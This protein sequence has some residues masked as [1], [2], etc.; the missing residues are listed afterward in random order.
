MKSE[1][2][3]ISLCIREIFTV[4]IT[5]NSKVL[6]LCARNRLKTR[7]IF[8]IIS[9]NSLPSNMFLLPPTEGTMETQ[10]M[11]GGC[12][13]E[14]RGLCHL[15]EGEST[16]HRHSQSNL[17]AGVRRSLPGPAFNIKNIC[18]RSAQRKVPMPQSRYFIKHRVY[19]QILSDHCLYMFGNCLC[20]LK[21]SHDLFPV[22]FGDLTEDYRL[23]A[24]ILDSRDRSQ[25]T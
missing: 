5:E 17:V 24:G 14:V 21:T 25:C 9:K 6:G 15:S 20:R 18:F 23:G 8:L 13:R 4:F 22:S 11:E 10:G 12:H 19:S 2:P 1:S 3:L 7:Y 16:I